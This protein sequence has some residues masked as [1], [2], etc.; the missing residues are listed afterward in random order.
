VLGKREAFEDDKKQLD[1]T[2][3]RIAIENLAKYKSLESI[4]KRIWMNFL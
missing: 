3:K 1:D 4:S 2:E